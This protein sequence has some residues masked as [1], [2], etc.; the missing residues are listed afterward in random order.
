MLNVIVL[1]GRLVEHPELKQTRDGVNLCHFTVANETGYGE[2]KQTNFVDCTAW[3]TT[4]EFIVKWFK[5]GDQI[6]VDGQLIQRRY[7]DK[8]GNHRSA[9]EINVREATFMGGLPK[10][11]KADKP[12]LPEDQRIDP[13][14]E[15][16]TDDE[17]L[18]F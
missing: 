8:E 11:E 15:D 9:Y 6:G 2:R 4:A 5:K 16:V 18:P 17:D 3:K 1:Q 10:E 12:V 14:F 7:L 13:K